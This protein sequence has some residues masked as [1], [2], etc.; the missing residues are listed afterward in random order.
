VG[1]RQFPKELTAAIATTPTALHVVAGASLLILLAKLLWLDYEPGAFPHAEELGKLVNDLL[2]A[3]LAAYLFFL[4]SFQ[5]PQVIERRQ[6]GAGIVSLGYRAAEQVMAL[7]LETQQNQDTSFGNLTLDDVLQRF[8]TLRPGDRSP[9]VA[10]PM[11]AERLT[12]LHAMIACKEDLC[13]VIEKLWRYSK[14]IDSELAGLLNDLEA[15]S[16]VRSMEFMKGLASQP[17]LFEND[18][19]L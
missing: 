19:T 12:W 13:A 7:Y 3:T 1:L 17:V 10:T 6:A 11:S 16:F 18:Q 8:R 14:F 15:S 2:S 4:I 9:V 5:V